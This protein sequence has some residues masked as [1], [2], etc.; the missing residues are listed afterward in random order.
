MLRV[1]VA[2]GAWIGGDRWRVFAVYAYLTSAILQ[3]T[4]ACK[5]GTIP[6]AL[7]MAFRV[8]AR[9]WAHGPPGTVTERHG[10]GAGRVL[11]SGFHGADAGLLRLC[12]WQL[13]AD[14]P[15]ILPRW[16]GR[17]SGDPVAIAADGC[18]RA[19]QNMAAAMNHAAFQRGQCAWPALV[20]RAGAWGGAITDGS[21]GLVGRRAYGGEGQSS[22]PVAALRCGRS[23][24]YGMTA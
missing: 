2:A 14:D 12:R 22:D 16:L 19:A 5:R 23:L 7:V 17:R 15:V 3:T 10:A 8:G 21:N 4:G 20:A 11:L 18:R 13:A 9:R 6:V 1:L 24:A